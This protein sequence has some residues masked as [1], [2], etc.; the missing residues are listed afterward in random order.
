MNSASKLENLSE[1]RRAPREGLARRRLS[2]LLLGVGFDLLYLLL[3]IPVSPWLLYIVLVRRRGVG[4]IKERLGGVSLSPS[5]GPRVWLHAVSVG[6]LEAALPLIKEIEQQAP[7]IEVVISTTTTTAQK[8]ARQ[9]LPGHQ[10]FLFPLDFGLCVRRTLR[11][12]RPDLLLLVE[13]ELWPNLT[14]QSTARGIPIAIVNGR[15]SPRGMQRM[16]RIRWLLRPLFQRLT[17]VLVQN[18]EYASRMQQVGVSSQQ[19]EVAGNLKF[20]R[21]IVPDPA[22]ERRQFDA[23][24][25]L[26]KRRWIAGCTHPGEGQKIADAHAEL[27]QQQQPVGLIVAPR[28]VER[29]AEVVDLFRSRGWKVALFSEGPSPEPVEVLVVDVTGQLSTLYACADAAFVGGSLIPR[30]GHNLLEPVAAGA[31]TAH[32]P[33]T[34]N[35]RQIA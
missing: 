1:L 23:S 12:V 17:R 28:H 24:W 21:Q 6:E 5:S 13:L 27:R 25:P 31:P 10:Q 4:S 35:F 11:R 14:L 33:F 30:G 8:L 34:S 18:A 7:G 9:K 32:G 26:P 22:A 16:R 20:D 19:I 2:A 15:M 3:L 29:S